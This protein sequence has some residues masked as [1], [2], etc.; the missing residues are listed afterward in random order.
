MNINDLKESKYLKKTDVDPAVLVTVS[1]TSQENLALQGQ[2]DEHKWVL[3]FKENIKPLVL[4]VTN[5]EIIAEFIGSEETDDW[6]GKQV[7]LY[8]DPNIMFQ[9][10]R[11][12]GIRARAPKQKAEAVKT[13]DDFDDDVPF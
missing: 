2:P 4:N 11:T 12:G 13:A 3:H 5:A 1:G 10:K 8:N 6:I 7:V 9:G